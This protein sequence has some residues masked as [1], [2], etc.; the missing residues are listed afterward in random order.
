MDAVNPIIN[1]E[2]LNKYYSNFHALKD[3]DLTVRSGERVV[4]CGPSVS[5]KSTF[6]RCFN[7]LEW[8]NYGKLVVDGIELYEGSKEVRAFCQH[9]GMV[10]QQF[11][12]FPHLTMLVNL[13]IGP[14][15]VQ[16][17]SKSEAEATARKYLG[18]VHIPDQAE[19]Y[20]A[21]L[22]GGQQQR[23]AIARSLCMEN[24]V[25]LFDE[26]TS[27]F[28]P[29][30]IKEIVKSTAI[31]S[32][33]AVAEL[34]TIGHNIISDT[35]LNFKIW[36]TIATVYIVVAMILSVIVSYAEKR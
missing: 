11:N 13:T 9:V 18:R 21:Q 12:L 24:R 30:M 1:V 23:V 4:I 14:I 20:P 2:K 17:F 33:I 22:S 10:F 16:K 7:G 26:P 6:I 35:Y 19:K 8:H 15:R 27:A 5:G 36:F 25:I 3:V 32:V 29:E 34:A 28:A 31:V